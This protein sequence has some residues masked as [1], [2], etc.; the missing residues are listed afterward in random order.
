MT[1]NRE[2]RSRSRVPTLLRGLAILGMILLSSIWTGVATHVGA[3]Y[4][5]PWLVAA[6]SALH[7]PVDSRDP[8][9]RTPLFVASRDGRS[10]VVEV[11]LRNGADPD[12]ALHVGVEKERLE[13]VSVLLVAGADPNFP[14]ESGASP[15]RRALYRSDREV[16]AEIVHLLLRSGADLAGHD[17]DS[18]DAL[19]I[20]ARGSPLPLVRALV[21]AGA[22]LNPPGAWPPVKVAVDHA[23][24]DVVKL[25]LEAGA[26]PDSEGGWPAL[27]WAARN[28]DLASAELLLA[29]GADP[30]FDPLSPPLHTAIQ[31][32]HVA[33]VRLLL[34]HEA[35]PNVIAFGAFTSLGMAIS[36]GNEVIVRL[37]IE[38]GADPNGLAGG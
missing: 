37:L 21:D 23:R 16:G 6:S 29:F 28:Q 1:E 10:R 22:D 31:K 30:N 3:I 12:L 26:N 7:G 15:L 2:S 17:S 19:M 24:P 32:E 9:G 13:I 14:S 8:S 33:M 27:L 4:G 25:L 38:A 35:D 34:E 18:R 20:A 5:L 11:L 36:D